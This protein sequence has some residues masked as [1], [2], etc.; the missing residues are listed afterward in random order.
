M[1]SEWRRVPI[2]DVCELIVDCVNKTAPTVNEPTPYKMV[3]TPNV[4]G[5]RVSTADCKF[6]TEHTFE[7]WTRRA[8]VRVNDVLLTREAPLGEVGIVKSHEKLFLGQRLMQYRANRNV[9]DPDYLVYAFLS[10]DLQHQFN[11]HEGSGSVVSHIRVGDC[12]KFE[13]NLPPLLIQKRI[14]NILGTL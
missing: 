3:R 1:G 14:A 6:V 9:L 7:K 12:S 10:R 2:S 8:E 13:L 11:M 5:G 4:K